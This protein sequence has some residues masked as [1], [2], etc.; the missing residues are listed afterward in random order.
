[1]DGVKDAPGHISF[2]LRN[3][4]LRF[5]PSI[6][7]DVQDEVTA[8]F[9]SAIFYLNLNFQQVKIPLLFDSKTIL[10]YFSPPKLDPVK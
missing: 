4:T 2:K 7:L 6:T 10:I 1:M 8:I 9:M 3:V 5:Y